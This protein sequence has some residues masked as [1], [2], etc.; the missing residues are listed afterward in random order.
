MDASYASIASITV[1]NA[2]GQPHHPKTRRRHSRRAAAAGGPQRPLGGRRGAGDPARGSP[3]SICDRSPAGFAG[4]CRTVGFARRGERA[5]ARHPDHRRRHR[6]LQ[7]AG[8]DPAAEGAAHSRPLR[9]DPR[10]PAVR[11]PAQRQRTVERARLR[12]SVRSGQRVRRRPYPPRP[13]L[14]PDRGGARNRRPDGEDGAGPCRRSR[15]RHP[16]RGQPAD[17][18]GA[19]DEPADVEQCRDPP[20]CRA[21]ATRRHRHGRAQCRRDGRSGRGRRRPDGGANRKSPPPPKNSCAR[22]SRARWRENAC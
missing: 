22:R 11:H 17:P 16:A 5:C 15:Q 4:P 12:R 8:P 19:G 10:R 1:G 20:Q 13:R 9:A 2:H 18:A 14:R 21:A 7:G 6:R 3:T